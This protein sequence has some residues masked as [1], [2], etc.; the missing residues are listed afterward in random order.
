MLWRT[1]TKVTVQMTKTN[2]V[3]I[4]FTTLLGRLHEALVQGITFLHA[5]P[6]VVDFL[7]GKPVLCPQSDADIEYDAV[8]AGLRH[9]DTRAAAC[10]AAGVKHVIAVSSNWDMAEDAVNVFARSLYTMLARGRGIDDGFNG[11][12]FDVSR[13]NIFCVVD[14]SASWIFDRRTSNVATLNPSSMP[15][16]RP[17]IV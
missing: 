12:T 1:I 2:A 7:E 15:R 8:V 16:P 3:H 9:V 5:S 6:S 17:S 11:T 14:V 4:R 10:L 13:S